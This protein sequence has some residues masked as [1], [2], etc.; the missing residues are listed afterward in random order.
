MRLTMATVRSQLSAS[1]ARRFR[2]ARVM[3]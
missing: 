3:V 1:T 2:P